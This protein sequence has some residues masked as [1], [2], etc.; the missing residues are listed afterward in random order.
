LQ[1]L[2]HWY[3]PPIRTALIL[4][5]TV[6]RPAGALSVA[7]RFDLR[8]LHLLGHE[9]EDMDRITEALLSEF[10]NEFG[11]SELAEDERFE[12]FTAWLTVRRHYSE[13]TFDPGESVTGKGNDT[14][15]DAIAVIA[16]NNLVTDVDQIEDL[17]AVNHHLDISFVFV[18]S[19][20][21]P[22]FDA[23]KI[24]NFGFGVND[25]FGNQK[26]P[27]N[28]KVHQYDEI[29]NACFE[30]SSKFRP[31][32]PTC[33]LYY[34]TT[35]QFNGDATLQT[36]VDAV[37]SDLSKTGMFSK[38]EFFCYG[39]SDIQKLYRASKNAISR[40]FIFEQKTVLPEVAGAKEA[41]L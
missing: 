12:R 23:Q 7:R 36:R 8:R 3:I 28:E 19:E 26:L 40:E 39:A 2:H 11:V 16:N 6:A 34:V 27:R 24:G 41:Y 13:T 20:R 29:M 15:I 14:G 35:G 30:H 33:S 32:N 37:I 5:Q 10:S 9:R 4:A 31:H 1:W 17:L 25:F 21:S 38:V 18:Q 22:H